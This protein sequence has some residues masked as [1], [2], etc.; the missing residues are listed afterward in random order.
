LQGIIGGGLGSLQ[1]WSSSLPRRA[2][3]FSQGDLTFSRSTI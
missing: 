1:F 3:F 2:N